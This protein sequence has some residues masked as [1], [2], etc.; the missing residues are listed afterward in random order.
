MGITQSTESEVVVKEV[1]PTT[2]QNVSI[3]KTDWDVNNFKIEDD[4]L[5]ITLNK[6]QAIVANVD[7]IVYMNDKIDIL[8]LNINPNYVEGVKK[9]VEAAAEGA[10]LP[11]GVTEAVEGATLPEGVPE[12]AAE[13]VPVAEMALE[14]EGASPQVGG[15]FPVKINM[16]TIY[17]HDDQGD[18]KFSSPIVGQIKQIDVKQG[19]SLY[20]IKSG[21]F[22][23]TYQLK[24]DGFT[25]DINSIYEYNVQKGLNFINITNPQE[26]TEYVWIY[27]FGKVEEHTVEAGSV[28]KIPIEKLLAI[29]NTL[30]YS[31]E[32]KGENVFIYFTGPITFYT[33]SKSAMG[34]YTNSK[35]VLLSQLPEGK[36]DYPI[37]IPKP[38]AVATKGGRRMFRNE[39]KQIERQ[40]DPIK[41]YDDLMKFIG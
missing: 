17:S 26:L 30:K 39:R 3:E 28:L 29:K 36:K 7:S 5:E 27:G 20:V 21:L 37:E 15:G 18:I 34:L 31:I 4:S 11:E 1:Q 16:Q 19:E 10:T 9:P 22:G 33:H 25:P 8:P 14:A 6:N 12:A 2:I 13:G 35:T 23:Y 38:V 41:A 32:R 40:N 24:V